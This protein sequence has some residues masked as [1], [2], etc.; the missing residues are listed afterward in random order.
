MKYEKATS[1]VIWFDPEIEF[2]ATSSGGCISVGRI[3]DN[4]CNNVEGP[5]GRDA[6]RLAKMICNNVTGPMN[7]CNYILCNAVETPICAIYDPHG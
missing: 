3:D 1:E 7:P 2:L 5:F 6:E 4:I